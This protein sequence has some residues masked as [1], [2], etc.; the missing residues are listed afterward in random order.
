MLYT[1]VYTRFLGS[2]HVVNSD[3]KNLQ[4]QTYFLR[5][6]SFIVVQNMNHSRAYCDIVV[7]S[8]EYVQYGVN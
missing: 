6:E 2:H 7:V 1:A 5:T 4:F 3:T 8:S